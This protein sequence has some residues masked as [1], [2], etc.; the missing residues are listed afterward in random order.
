M[1][2]TTAID[3]TPGPD[4]PHSLLPC[5]EMAPWNNLLP[6][7]TYLLW[8]ILVLVLLAPELAQTCFTVL[9]Q[10]LGAGAGGL[11]R[12]SGSLALGN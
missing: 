6:P 7:Q 2:Y 9:L 10:H 11:Y 5:P 8:Y 12:H 1:V 3:P 4:S